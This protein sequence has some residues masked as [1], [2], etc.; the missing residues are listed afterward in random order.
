[1]SMSRH[2]MKAADKA[3]C[4]YAM[5]AMKHIESPVLQC[6]LHCMHLQFAHM[7]WAVNTAITAEQ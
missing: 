2:S 3:G 7:Q 1:M 5:R 4:V 6:K